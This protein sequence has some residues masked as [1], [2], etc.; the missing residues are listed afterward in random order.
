MD[1]LANK[2]DGLK[3][4][5]AG[6]EK[7]IVAFSGGVDSTFLAKVAYDVLGS[8]ALAVTATSETYPSDELEE[9][10]KLAQLIGIRHILIE[11][12][13]LEIPGYS[14]NP[15]N[16]CYYCKSELFTKLKDVLDKENFK[17]IADGSN[18]DD[19]N[20]YRPGMTAA[21]ELGVVS[22]LKEAGLTKAD[23]R[24]LSRMLGLPTWDKPSFACL[25]SRFPYGHD[26]TIE[27][28]RM[29]DQAEKFLRQFKFKQLRV[30]IHGDVA[31]IEVTKEDMVRFFEGGLGEQVAKKLKEIGFNYITLDLQGYRTGS[32][33]EVLS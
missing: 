5:L 26:I 18:Y 10:K 6:L 3:R 14:K 21:K 13:E 23:I 30:R 19:Q 24:V 22:P 17:F 9:A 20:D 15:T 25:S 29:V 8:G 11:S 4:I 27:K 31:R 7:V 16:R 28:L 2:Y 33:N 32:M 1:E 12:N